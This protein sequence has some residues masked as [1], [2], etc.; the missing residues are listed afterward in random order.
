MTS[1]DS[2]FTPGLRVDA[3][4][5]VRIIAYGSE[6]ST[7]VDVSY[8]LLDDNGVVL[9]GQHSILMSSRY[10]RYSASIP[11]TSGFLLDVSCHSRG[12]TVGEGVCF[13]DVVLLRGS[14][15][16][17]SRGLKLCSGGFGPVD[18]LSWPAKQGN[19][20]GLSFGYQLDQA[21]TAPAAGNPIAWYGRDYSRCRVVAFQTT[22][23]TDATVVNRYPYV[24]VETV[25]GPVY[26][27]V[28]T[29]AQTASTAR[30][31]SAGLGVDGSIS[32]GS[33]YESFPIP[34]AWLDNNASIKFGAINMVAG[35]QF[36]DGV[37]LA[38][39]RWAVDGEL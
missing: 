25:N 1:Q 17:G 19:D 4:D 10:S 16:S 3:N 5:S 34:P 21:I 15:S 6:V 23:E 28:S 35:D 29:V 37:L 2:L 24:E 8:R 39:R 12:A 20:V 11:L 27:R 14:L 32:V 26:R 33:G 31:L 38:D 22:L 18:S 13:A 36:G 30:V 9:S 7:Y